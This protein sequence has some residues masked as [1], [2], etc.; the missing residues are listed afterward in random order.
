MTNESFSKYLEQ[1]SLPIGGD[2]RI[3]LDDFSL[4]FQIGEPNSLFV[5]HLPAKANLLLA[6]E[7]AYTQT[8][9]KIGVS[10][11][12]KIGQD[13][14]DARYVIRDP[15]GLASSVLTTE[16][17]SAVQALEPFIEL[18]LTG[19]QYRLLKQIDDEEQ[20]LDLIRRFQQLVELTRS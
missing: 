10:G 5:A 12:S 15:Q 3:K 20:G 14:F 17:V 2:L 6:P 4:S 9:D 8:A 1:Q 13:D 19:K 7:S 11:E 18:E 16:V